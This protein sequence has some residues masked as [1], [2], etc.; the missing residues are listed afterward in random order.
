[1]WRKRPARG[2]GGDGLQRFP[3]GRKA[4]PP[5]RLGQDNCRRGG[6]VEALHHA[7]RGDEEARGRPADGVGREA[8]PLVAEPEGHAG[9]RRRLRGVEVRAGQ[10]QRRGHGGVALAGQAAEALRRALEG[11]AAAAVARAARE[12]RLLGR[13]RVPRPA[14]V[15]H[16]ADLRHAEGAA[17]PEDPLDVVQVA[18]ILQHDGHALADGRLLRRPLR[19][20][21]RISRHRRLGSGSW[22]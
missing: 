21:G 3:T 12:V 5:D 8:V 2:R 4:P 14:A 18:G 22:P 6:D 20:R 7:G 15:Q 17:D 13:P 19:H 1:M 16:V 9:R 11:P 10:L